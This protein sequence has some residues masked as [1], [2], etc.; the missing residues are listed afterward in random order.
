MAHSHGCWQQWASLQH[1]S[2]LLP[3]PVTSEGESKGETTML[4]TYSQRSRLVFRKL[5]TLASASFYCLKKSC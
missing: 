5:Q 2:W 3:E 1:D 4:L